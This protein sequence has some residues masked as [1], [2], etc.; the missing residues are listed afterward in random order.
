M[1]PFHDTILAVDLGNELSCV[2]DSWSAPPAAV[3]RWSATMAAAIRSAYPQALVVSG[4]DSGPIFQDNGWRL[5]DLPGLDFLS[6]HTY[7]V[8]NWNVVP[9]DGMTDPFCQA[10]LPFNTRVARAFAPVMVQEFSSIL[11]CGGPEC[12]SYLGAILPACR[13][14][15]A[16]GFL[17]WCLRDIRTDRMPYAKHGFEGR[18][19]LVGADDRVKPNL[20]GMM[21]LFREFRDAGPVRPAASDLGLYWPRQWYKRDNP[22]NPGNDAT[23]CY[24]RMLA[25]HYSLAAQGR[26]AAIVRG[27]QPIPAGIRTLVVAGHALLCEESAALAAWVRQ[28]GKLIWSGPTWSQWD[29]SVDAV[30]GAQPVDI[31]TPRPVTVECFGG[32]WA[33]AHYPSDGRCIARVT[34][35][36]VIAAGD[37]GQPMVLAN[38]LGKGRAVA[39]L[40]QPEETMLAVGADRAARDRWQRWHAGLLGE[41]EA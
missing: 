10:I 4:L 33:L 41:V 16:N 1:A 23:A 11:T 14:A 18:L 3:R 29:T 24:R 37:D 19:G 39:V 17:W 9:F 40:A 12:D 20:R 30:L 8:P 38:T 36:R 21:E 13:A 28:G 34:T 31:R 26:T 2:P 5:G 27:D 25:T 32:R 6:V 7:P 22:Q 15:G 35:A